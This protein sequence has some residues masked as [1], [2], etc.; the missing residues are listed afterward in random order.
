M[1]AGAGASKVANDHTKGKGD[2][3]TSRKRLAVALGIGLLTVFG[4]L[5]AA[6]AQYGAP[7]PYYGPPPAARGVYR[8]GLVFGGSVGAG[9]IYAQ[10]CDVYCGAAGMIEGHI[11]GMLNPRLA[12]VGDF[13]GS[14]HPWEDLYGTGTTYHGIYTFGVQYWV[15]P[16]VWLKGGLGFG[17]MQLQGDNDIAPFGEESGLAAM[18]AGGVEV[19]QSYNFTLDLQLRLGHGFYTG[20]GDVNNV[21]F[22]VGINWY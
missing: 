18:G 14:V 7:R 16:I 1:K 11:G 12:L 6:Q 2:H 20:G 4:S 10:D 22:M 21:G 17:H 19:V 15:A 13:W 9:G 8:S 5:S 3:M